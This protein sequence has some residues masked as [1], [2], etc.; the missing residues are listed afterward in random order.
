M[1]SS[2]QAEVVMGPNEDSMNSFPDND[3]PAVIANSNTHTNNDGAE[4]GARDEVAVQDVFEAESSAPVAAEPSPQECILAFKEEVESLRKRPRSEKIS[5]TIPERELFQR[6]NNMIRVCGLATQRKAQELIGLTSLS[7]RIRRVCRLIVSHEVLSTNGSNFTWKLRVRAVLPDSSPISISDFAKRVF[8]ETENNVNVG[9]WSASK[10]AGS[11]PVDEFVITRTSPLPTVARIHI[12]L[13]ADPPIF[14]L[15]PKLASLLGL[16]HE[17]MLGVVS[18]VMAYV[19]QHSL[20]DADDRR[21]INCDQDLHELLGAARIAVCHIQ[22]LIEKHIDVCEAFVVPYEVGTKSGAKVYES[23]IDTHR[24]SDSAALSLPPVTE[25]VFD[26]ETMDLLRK[27]QTARTRHQFFSRLA[28]NPREFMTEYL[29][30]QAN[31]LRILQ[32]GGGLSH[33]SREEA[34]RARLWQQP[35]VEESVASYVIRSFK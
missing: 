22:K 6:V 8:F 2:H 23:I 9:E 27:V 17:T 29:E 10:I 16:E 3:G 7:N 25:D 33:A 20:Q 26:A 4:D 18:R 13:D 11:Q 28:D 1:E 21:Y 31:D 15:H 24:D 12:S 35:W 5:N 32:Q 14:R 30:S 19:T 34:S